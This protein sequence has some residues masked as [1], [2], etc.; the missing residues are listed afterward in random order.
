[1]NNYDRKIVFGTAVYIFVIILANIFMINLSDRLCS[2]EYKLSINRV[3]NGICDFEKSRGIAPKDLK[4]LSEFTGILDYPYISEVEFIPVDEII[5]DRDNEVK[6]ALI[7]EFY[8]S[9]D[10]DYIAFITDKNYYKIRYKLNSSNEKRDILFI[11]NTFGFVLLAAFLIFALFIRQKILVPFMK[12][13]NMPYELSRGNLTIPLKEEKGKYFGRFIWGMDL[14]REKLEDSRMRELE[15][16]KEK[17]LLLLSLSHD[18]KTPLSA[19]KLYA[20][21]L[22]RNLYKSEDKKNEIAINIDKKVDEIEGFISEIVKASSE[23]FLEFEVD[24]T[25]FYI[26]NVLDNIKDYYYEKMKLNRIDFFV[27]Q[28]NNCLVYG[29]ADRF[30]QVCQNIIENAIKYGDGKRIWIDINREGERYNIFINNTGCTLDSR[31]LLHICDSFFR[32]SNI[33]N[34][35]GSG[36]GLYICRKLMHLMEGEVVVQIENKD[37]ERIMK[38][39]LGLNIA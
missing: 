30:V 28:Y 12:F 13:S 1:M 32:G 7:E 21:A 2:Y 39:Q 6:M 22:Y 33:G 25:N 19:I 9:N 3:K 27:G 24:N 35:R 26:G 14:L 4:E 10:I 17:K 15:L 34:N 23:D 37:D 8:N 20:K 5:S 11:I 31:E 29:D 38:V 16:Q 36:L 18:I